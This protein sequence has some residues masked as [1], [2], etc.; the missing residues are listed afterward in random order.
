V[1]PLLVTMLLAQADA[2]VPTMVDGKLMAHPLEGVWQ[3]DLAQSTDTAPIL[4]KLGVN[5][6]VRQAAKSA[7]PIH[8]LRV[9]DNTLFLEIEA[10]IAK[11]RYQLVVDG[12]SPTRDEFFGDPFEYTTVLENGAFVS[13]GKM[14][15]PA[16]KAGITLHRSLREDG[17]M[18]YRITLM[19]D[20]QEPIVIN[21]VF[22]RK[23]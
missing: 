16:K 13:N 11:K 23:P 1:T 2:G 22:R 21:R 5:W 8:R 10:S 7:R 4:E 14:T 19:P 9:N 17:L 15:D 20:G 12:K 6:F 3:L 18:L